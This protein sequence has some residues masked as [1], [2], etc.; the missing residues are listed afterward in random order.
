MEYNLQYDYPVNMWLGK[1]TALDMTQLVDWVV[2]PQHKQNLGKLFRFPNTYG[3][4]SYWQI[5]R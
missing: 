5:D 1:L 4:L 3:A 2:K